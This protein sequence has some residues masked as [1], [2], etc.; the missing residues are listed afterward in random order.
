MSETHPSPQEYTIG[1][2]G[3]K[4]PR[5]DMEDWHPTVSGFFTRLWKYNDYGHV[6][7]NGRFTLTDDLKRG[8]DLVLNPT[9]TM[10][11]VNLRG[12]YRETS[13]AE[14]EQQLARRPS[15]SQDR[16]VTEAIETHAILAAPLIETGTQWF[17][18]LRYEEEHR[19]DV[20]PDD[21]PY[22]KTL[23]RGLPLTERDVYESKRSDE[24]VEQ[25]GARL[26]A[27]FTER[28]RQL[29]AQTVQVLS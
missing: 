17:P 2:Q 26:D 3:L 14:R 7:S 18:I 15:W 11:L 25:H 21:G 10:R 29:L 4:I 19:T 5:V 1:R 24:S 20:A 8:I 28:V 27:A 16:S 23:Y 13:Q 9:P 6:D 22:T 12:S